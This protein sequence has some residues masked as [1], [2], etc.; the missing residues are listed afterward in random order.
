MKDQEGGE[1][2]IPLTNLSLNSNGQVQRM[3][4][5]YDEN[6]RLI[7][8]RIKETLPEGW[9][10]DGER[11][12]NG[13]LVYYTEPFDLKAEQGRGTA[14]AEQI[15]IKNTRYGSFTLNK[16]FYAA[17]ENG[18]Q[19]TEKNEKTNFYLYQ[20]VGTDGDIMPYSPTSSYTTENGVIKVEDLPVGTE[21]EPIYYYWAEETRTDD[22]SPAKTAGG[23]EGKNLQEI[24][25]TVPGEGGTP[26][27]NKV[28]A[29]GPYNFLDKI[30]GTEGQVQLD[31]TV[32]VSNIQQK[33]PVV[34]KK[35]S[36]ADNT[37]VSGAKYT[38]YKLN[39]KGEQAE[40]V[41]SETEITDSSG[42]FKYLEP[43][44]KYE[45]VETTVPKGYNNAN[46]GKLIIDL[47][48]ISI[49]DTE[50]E[51][52]EVT[53][54][55]DPDPTIQIEKTVKNANG[56]SS[57]LTDI[58]FEIYKKDAD[59][60][61]ERATDYEGKDLSIKPG[62]S[63]RLPAGQYYFRETGENSSVLDPEKFTSLYDKKNFEQ[64]DGKVYFGPFNVK[65]NDTVQK[66][67]IEKISSMG[68]AQITKKVE[69]NAESP[70]GAVFKICRKDKTGKIIELGS[71]GAPLTVTTGI[72]GTAVFKDLPIYEKTDTGY[73]KYTYYIQEVTPPAGCTLNPVEL[74]LKL[75]PGKIVTETII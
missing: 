40:T 28:Q 17:T 24:L 32:D 71:N 51:T 61:F 50:T 68:A 3:L 64:K 35:V 44:Y 60:D 69:N 73:T 62:T 70:R 57:T 14:G 18:I 11:E 12:E 1:T 9:H 23:T 42:S 58:T 59:G 48:N 6:N 13:Q 19:E 7:Q 30:G 31:R 27:T 15:T 72:D 26:T 33:V 25:V 75:A 41:V 63:L 2:D 46:E 47:T 54:K 74:E 16:T 10:A 38:I 65:D 43:G 39:E 45:V 29:Y 55:N 66:F 49:V 36:T 5:V 37:F 20:Q 8:Y 34:V 21:Q 56:S 22:Y 53:I 4:P 67:T 52:E